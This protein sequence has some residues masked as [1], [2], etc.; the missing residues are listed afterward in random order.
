MHRV[1]AAPALTTQR[2]YPYRVKPQAN[3]WLAL[4]AQSSRTAPKSRRPAVRA[5][6]ASDERGREIEERIEVPE[7]E[8]RTAVAKPERDTGG[9]DLQGL[10]EQ[11]EMWHQQSVLAVEKAR[12]IEDAAPDE[13]PRQAQFDEDQGRRRRELREKHARALEQE[14]GR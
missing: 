9:Q 4:P 5:R 11:F 13:G 10:D 8:A 3:P 6:G 14:L 2:P 7:E 12:E 1:L